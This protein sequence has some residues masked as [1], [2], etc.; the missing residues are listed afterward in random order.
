MLAKVR[1][2]NA[3]SSNTISNDEHRAV[4]RLI[5]KGKFHFDVEYSQFGKRD[6]H[7]AVMQV[8]GCDETSAGL[9]IYHRGHQVER[10]DEALSC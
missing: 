7:G 6:H 5:G 4:R 10:E 1:S 8:Y 2:A 3:K 9:A